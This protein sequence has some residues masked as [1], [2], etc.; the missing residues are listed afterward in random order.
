MDKYHNIQFN[1]F[2]RTKLVFE[3]LSKNQKTDGSQKNM[4]TA[5]H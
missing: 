1:F 3:S 5:Q 2:S 4:R